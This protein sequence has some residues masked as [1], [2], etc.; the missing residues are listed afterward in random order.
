M[1]AALDVARKMGRSRLALVVMASVAVLFFSIAV[2]LPNFRLIAQVVG[3]EAFTFGGKATFLM[4]V[5]GS[6]TTNF[7]VPSQIIIALTALFAGLNAALFVILF[8][9]RSQVMG[10]S[11]FSMGGGTLAGMFG[12]GCASCGSIVL[13]SIL[14]IF[15]ISAVGVLPF[16]G[17]EFG[18][19]GV[20][21]LA[22]AA[23]RTVRHIQ[24]PL[25]CEPEELK[26]NV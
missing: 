18:V 3:S 16:G 21:V 10:G 15:G 5:I 9:Q 6:Y 11:M 19:L 17:V 13:T 22:Y 20:G 26:K 7:D 24:A 14:P 1:S 2:S 4:S 8:R 23:K 25:V 12:I